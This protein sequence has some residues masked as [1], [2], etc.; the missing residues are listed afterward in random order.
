M[1]EATLTPDFI[2]DG[3]LSKLLRSKLFWALFCLFFF[4]YPLLRSINRTLPPDLPVMSAL[5]EYELVDENGAS[6]GSKDLKGK[7]Y[8]ANFHFTSCPT[9]CV[10]LMETTQK[11]QKRMKSMGQKVAIVSFTVDPENDQPKVLFKKARELNANPYVWKF[12]TGTKKQLS[13]LLIKGFKVP[14]GEKPENVDLYDIAHTGKIVLVDYKGDIR[15]YYSSDQNGV[16]KL[17]IDIGLIVNRPIK[18]GADN[19]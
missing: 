16:N 15:G 19:V 1:S 6:F 11:I 8:L 17:M 13:N 2:R 9:I 3:M 14:M 10:K 4:S 18:I 7:F 5:P 12:L